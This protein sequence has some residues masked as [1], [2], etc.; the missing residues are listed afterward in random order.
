MADNTTAKVNLVKVFKRF[1]IAGVVLELELAA[2][3]CFFGASQI[4]SDFNKLAI[5]RLWHLR[6]LTGYVSLGHS[7][8]ELPK[9]TAH[10]CHAYPRALNSGHPQITF[11]HGSTARRGTPGGQDLQ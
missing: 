10:R 1:F 4:R 9:M 8:L 2:E 11:H 5:G 6:T 7:L 3:A